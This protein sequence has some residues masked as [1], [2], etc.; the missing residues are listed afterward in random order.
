MRRGQDNAQLF[1]RQQSPGRGKLHPC[2]RRQSLRQDLTT[3]RRI[4]GEVQPPVAYPQFR[5][6][7]AVVGKNRRLNIEQPLARRPANPGCITLPSPAAAQSQRARPP[8]HGAGI[9]VR[10]TRCSPGPC[11]A[12]GSVIER[13][14]SPCRDWRVPLPAT[15]QRLG[16]LAPQRQKRS[17]YSYAE[18]R[19]SPLERGDLLLRSSL[20]G[21]ALI[22]YAKCTL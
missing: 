11:Q 7:M 14:V 19:R 20:H 22:P 21:R 3:F 9:C 6:R 1:D 5:L 13:R 15:R 4:R 10:Q 8:D 17:R 2:L 12:A 16:R 18:L